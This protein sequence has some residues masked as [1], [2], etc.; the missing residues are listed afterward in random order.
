MV[1]DISPAT[2]QTKVQFDLRYY[3][4]KRG[5]ENFYSMTKDTFELKFDTETK[6]A[7]KCQEEKR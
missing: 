4:C 7:Y 1:P 3:F 2:L 6:I 5:E